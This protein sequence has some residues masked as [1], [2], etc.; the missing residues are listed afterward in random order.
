MKEKKERIVVGGTFDLL[1][2][3]HF[4]ILYNA[5]EIGDVYAIVRRRKDVF[6]KK[7]KLTFQDDDTRLNN[8]SKIFF[9]RCEIM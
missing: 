4:N 7:D 2:S 8:I 6:E 5:N 9:K 1:H 3:G